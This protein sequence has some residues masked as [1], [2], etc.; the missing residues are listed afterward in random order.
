MAGRSPRAVLRGGSFPVMSEQNSDMERDLNRHQVR[1]FAW[2]V[3][4]LAFGCLVSQTYAS[5]VL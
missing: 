4:C 2:S 5:S 1:G 3:R